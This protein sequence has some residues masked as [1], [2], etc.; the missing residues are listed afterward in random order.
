MG[1]KESKKHSSICLKVCYYPLLC[2]KPISL[3]NF[4]SQI[5]YL[6]S[7]EGGGVWGGGGYF[8]CR[9]HECWCEGPL[10][11]VGDFYQ[12]SGCSLMKI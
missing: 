2:G 11:T 10:E 1:R 7:I 4:V 8:M 9:S 12:M 5:N 3:K 6:S